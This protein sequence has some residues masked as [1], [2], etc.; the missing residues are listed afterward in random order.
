MTVACKKDTI[1]RYG[2]GIQDASKCKMIYLHV[3]GYYG[4][5]LLEKALKQ[6]CP[7]YKGEKK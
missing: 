7:N 4:K 5:D 1:C 2:K 6:L 3:D